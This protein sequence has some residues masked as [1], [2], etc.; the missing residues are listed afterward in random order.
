[1]AEWHFFATSH[2][3]GACDG[4]GGTVKRLAACAS[5]QR[6][7]SDQIM[8]PRQLFEWCSQ[9]IQKIQ[10]NYVTVE[11]YKV[12]KT[13][14]S[15]RFNQ[16]QSIPGTR[17]FHAYI[18]LSTSTTMLKVQTFSGSERSIKVSII[19]EKIEDEDFILML[20][21]IRGFV[22]CSYKQNWWVACVLQTFSTTEEVQLSF[23]HPAGPNRSYYYPGKPE[24]RSLP[25]T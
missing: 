4:V 19:G 8:T 7:Y 3:K 21:D 9:N 25:L 13:L 16:C 10:F 23:L 18:P 24:V 6:P 1:M 12:E 20:D 5:L 2:G 22:T 15:E 17:S 14:L 11:D